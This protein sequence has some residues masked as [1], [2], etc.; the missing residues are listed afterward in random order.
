MFFPSRLSPPEIPVRLEIFLW[1]FVI[2][3]VY[4]F[5]LTNRQEIFAECQK[6]NKILRFSLSISV[7]ECDFTLVIF[8]LRLRNATLTL[9]CETS[10]F[11]NRLRCSSWRHKCN[12]DNP[13]SA[14]ILKDFSTSRVK[15]INKIFII[16]FSVKIYFYF[17]FA[18][19]KQYKIKIITKKYNNKYNKE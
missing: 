2:R 16:N 12:T 11:K 10:P 19:T 5:L 18:D 17:S 4:T 13:I 7:K 9:T 6:I 14:K 15:K 3:F 1:K 8:L